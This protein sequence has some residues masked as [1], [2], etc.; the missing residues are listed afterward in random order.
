MGLSYIGVHAVGF[1]VYA[2]CPV[3]GCPSFSIDDDLGL[4]EPLS[5]SAICRKLF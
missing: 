1:R 5:L 2:G 4:A 3:S